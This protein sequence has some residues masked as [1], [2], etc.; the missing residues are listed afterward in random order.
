MFRIKEP[1]STNWMPTPGDYDPTSESVERI[2][3]L[4]IM[5]TPVNES[6]DQLNKTLLNL[7]ALLLHR[8]YII[9]T[10][11]DSG[12]T[13]EIKLITINYLNKQMRL[14]LSLDTELSL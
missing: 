13:R 1:K 2:K 4:A 11:C 7:R 12:V 10:E 9:K 5:N 8:D 14:L 3:Q 6:S